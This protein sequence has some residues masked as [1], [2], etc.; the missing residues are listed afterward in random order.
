MVEQW[1]PPRQVVECKSSRRT[2]RLDPEVGNK[3]EPRQQGLQA[4]Q[5]WLEL[6]EE[7][8]ATAGAEERRAQGKIINLN[9]QVN[10]GLVYLLT[11]LLR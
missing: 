7:E 2:P 8:A 4:D 10:T 6:T 11:D 1:G 3:P 9:E 5:L